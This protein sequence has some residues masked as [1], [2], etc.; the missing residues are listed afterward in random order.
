MSHGG[1]FQFYIIIALDIAQG[2]TSAYRVT[3]ALNDN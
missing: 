3:K 2:G 1:I